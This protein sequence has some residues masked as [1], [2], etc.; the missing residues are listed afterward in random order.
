MTMHKSVG[1]AAAVGVVV[2][3]PAT[4]VAALGPA[5]AHALQLGSIN[6]LLWICIAPAQAAAAWV[7]AQLAQHASANALSRIFAASLAATG[8]IMLHSAFP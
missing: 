4:I 5:P 1:R 8:V 6:M 3:L 2:A 7:G